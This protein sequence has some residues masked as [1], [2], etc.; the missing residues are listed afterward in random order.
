MTP[1]RDQ[2]V[3][4]YILVILWYGWLVRGDG[5]IESQ[6]SRQRTFHFLHRPLDWA[7]VRPRRPVY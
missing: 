6:Q 1:F 4:D 5:V 2:I 7:A 3:G